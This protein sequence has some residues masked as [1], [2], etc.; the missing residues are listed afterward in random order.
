MGGKRCDKGDNGKVPLNRRVSLFE[1]LSQSFRSVNSIY[2]LISDIPT[3]MTTWIDV[4]RQAL[5]YQFSGEEMRVPVVASA[6]GVR[7]SQR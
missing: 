5:I 1:W 3:R 7:T 2:V 4:T 6:T